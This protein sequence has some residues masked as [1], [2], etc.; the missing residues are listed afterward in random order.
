[1]RGSM[2]GPS[3]LNHFELILKT[4]QGWG[5]EGN[6]LIKTICCHIM[7]TKLFQ[8]LSYLSL[9]KI[10][11]WTLN[12]VPSGIDLGEFT[13][14]LTSSRQNFVNK[15]DNYHCVG[16]EF[17]ALWQ[18]SMS[19]PELLK[20][21]EFIHEA[22]QECSSNFSSLSYLPLVVWPTLQLKSIWRILLNNSCKSYFIV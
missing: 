7:K 14:G 18:I 2:S 5:D 16:F 4:S 20:L 17:S 3:F 21:M 12:T 9:A 22:S 6:D 13:G 10:C 8:F 11:I 15:K 19:R 1:M